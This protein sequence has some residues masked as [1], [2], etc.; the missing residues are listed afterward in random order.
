M[1]S[2]PLPLWRRPVTYAAVGVTQDDDLV[3]FPP[4]GF[5]AIERKVRLGHGEERWHHAWTETL[6]WGIKT[7]SGFRVVHVDAPPE[8]SANTYTPVTFDEN[9]EPVQPAAVT[10]DEVYA[11]TGARIVRPGDSVVQ[12]LGGRILGFR[13]PVRVVTVIDEPT[14]KG[15][16]Y[17]TLPGH[18]LSGEE[19][20][21]VERRDDDSV[22][23]TIRSISRPAG[24]GWWL[25]LPVIRLVQRGFLS[26]Y[27]RAL[28]QPLG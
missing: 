3:R 27:E 8:V 9:G 26:R 2:S 6:T 23:L 22:W 19:S 11:D 5:T 17:G 21:L 16:A 7:R 13:E 18:P 10:A 4:K 1:S 12:M 14:R 28:S 24:P 25:L 15:F 20:F